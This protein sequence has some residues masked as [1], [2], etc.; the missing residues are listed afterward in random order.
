MPDFP[1]NDMSQDGKKTRPSAQDKNV[2]RVTKSRVIRK[3]RQG[4]P[5]ASSLAE[6]LGSVVTDVIVPRAL[7]VFVDASTQTIENLAY[8][9]NNKKP[10][11]TRSGGGSYISYNRYSSPSTA[12]RSEPAPRQRDEDRHINRKRDRHD[13]DD[14]ILESRAEANDVLDSLYELVSSYGYATVA[15]LYE[16]VGIKATYTDEN[17]GWTELH[18]TAVRKVR[19]GFIIDIPRPEFLD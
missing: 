10:R 6:S 18:S 7:D 4:N 9:T 11:R 16:L 3:K 19:R 12:R 17:W 13:F 1:S 5:F 15:D 14:I 2:K 8:G